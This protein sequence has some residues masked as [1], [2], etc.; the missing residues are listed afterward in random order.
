MSSIHDSAYS[1]KTCPFGAK[2]LEQELAATKLAAAWRGYAARE[3]ASYEEAL[4][5][6][7]LAKL[8]DEGPAAHMELKELEQPP[9]DRKRSAE[10]MSPAPKRRKYVTMDPEEGLTFRKYAGMSADQIEAE[11]APA[12]I[13]TF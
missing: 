7:G 1:L 11:L 9:R 8:D 5:A 13:K 6:H 4:A 3:L 12:P 10:P 2:Q